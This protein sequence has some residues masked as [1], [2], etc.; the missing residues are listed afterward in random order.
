MDGVLNIDK[1]V[2]PTSHDVVARVRR[3]IGQHRIGHTGTLD[4]LASGV[5]PLVVGRATRLARFLSTS[6][7]TYDATIRLGIETATYDAYGG[8]TRRWHGA[9]WPTAERIR[10]ALEVFRGEFAQQPPPFSAK[11]LRG[12]PAYKL[13]RD[14]KPPVLDAV[15]VR[16]EHLDLLLAV[17]DEVRLRV[18]CSAGFYVRSLAHDF[19]L[20]LGCGAHL[21]ALR[22]LRSGEFDVADAIPLDTVE[23]DPLEAER[24]LVP[25]DR[26]LA[27]IPGA[28]L[29]DRGA[30]RASHG[31]AIMLEDVER[32]SDDVA[33]PRW[34]LSAPGGS[35]FVRL[36]APGGRLVAIAVADAHG[37]PLRPTVV[38]V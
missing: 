18:R 12:V 7:K 17:G 30:S 10:A 25:L 8:E 21:A 4:P 27:S 6:D 35:R 23:R 2:G 26:L 38:V 22:R 31:Q 34:L 37:W 29:T 28:R 16:V 36:L 13:A 9:E 20:A 15:K 24:R 19:G 32:D 14:S 1:P 3:A 33:D 11:K 5:L